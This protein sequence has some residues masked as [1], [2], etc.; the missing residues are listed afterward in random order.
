MRTLDRLLDQKKRRD[1]KKNSAA[2]EPD[3]VEIMLELP[4]LES[5]NA[6]ASVFDRDAGKAFVGINTAPS[7]F[8][9]KAL[10]HVD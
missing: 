4:A 10:F 1:Q 8:D 5:L 9:K 6:A 2:Q 3:E 7:V